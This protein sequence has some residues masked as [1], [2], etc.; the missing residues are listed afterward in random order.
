TRT[1][2]PRPDRVLPADLHLRLLEQY[3]PPSLVVTEEHNIVHMSERVGRYMQVRGGEPTRDLLV[4]VLPE[5]RPDLRT[6][7]HE[8]S[9]GRK[10][11]EIHGVSVTVDG[12]ARQVDL[13]VR[14][15]L[16]DGDAAKGYFLVTFEERTDDAALP[17][18]A[19]TLSSPAEP[20]MRHLEE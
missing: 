10:N 7:L 11:V 3:A 20:L 19:A 2:E 5:L 1:P 6:A 15:V 14:P 16:R 4:L 18:P 13:A 12:V 17:T 9:K 8:A